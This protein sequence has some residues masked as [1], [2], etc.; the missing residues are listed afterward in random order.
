M[1]IKEKWRERVESDQMERG[2]KDT[3]GMGG[4]G[5]LMHGLRAAIAY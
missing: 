4:R 5:E 2:G 1:M 3:V